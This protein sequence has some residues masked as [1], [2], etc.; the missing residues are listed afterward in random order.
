[1]G[2]EHRKEVMKSGRPGSAPDAHRY[3]LWRLPADLEPGTWASD[4]LIVSMG[5]HGAMVVSPAG[6]QG[7]QTPES[8]AGKNQIDIMNHNL[9][10]RGRALEEGMKWEMRLSRAPLG[11]TQ[12]DFVAY[13]SEV[14]GLFTEWCASHGATLPSP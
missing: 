3:I 4:A 1:M 11:K 14:V 12:Q 10:E 9:A 7:D 5:E 6:H 2:K 13:Y 8:P